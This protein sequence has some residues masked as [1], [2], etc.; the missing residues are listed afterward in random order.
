MPRGERDA[1]GD[2]S[3]VRHYRRM[4]WLL[5]FGLIHAYGLLSGDILVLYSL[6][7]GFVFLLP[8]RSPRTLLLI[9]VLV[10][11]I[12]SL[13][14][15]GAY[16]GMRYLPRDEV[17]HIE[18]ELGRPSPEDIAQELANYRSGWWGQMPD[19]VTRSL[20]FQ[21]QVFWL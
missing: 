10:L 9:G 5:L 18:R 1:R 8:R 17:A 6:C 15:V 16:A 2:G 11:T 13:I 20:E 14:S 12:G 21:L 7:G 19:R 3:A 4:F